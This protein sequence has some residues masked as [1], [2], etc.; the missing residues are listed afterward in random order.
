MACFPGPPLPTAGGSRTV[1]GGPETRQ[2]LWTLPLDL[3]DP[4]HPKPG[5]PEP[6]LLTPANESVPRFSPDGRW[7]AYRS[8]ESGNPEIY[9]PFPAGVGGKW[10][11]S[12]GGGLYAF[13]SSNDREIFYETADNRIMVVDYTVDGASFVPSKPRVWFDKPLF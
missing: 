3:T 11:I 9:R 1:G 6:F 12:S 7:I 4:D 5:K 2:D 13:W 8:D 10:Q